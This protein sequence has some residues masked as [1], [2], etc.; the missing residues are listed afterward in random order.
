MNTIHAT[1]Q[2]PSEATH[3]VHLTLAAIR[4][5]IPRRTAASVI[6]F[7]PAHT[8]YPTCWMHFPNPDHAQ[9]WAR[10]Q[11]DACPTTPFVLLD[12]TGI[13]TST[14]T[15]NQDEALRLAMQAECHWRDATAPRHR[16]IRLVQQQINYDC[17]PGQPPGLVP[18]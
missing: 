4:R 18:A 17:P 1:L 15:P 12:A 10:L 6:M 7:C 9:E 8:W 2:W 3:Y 16:T 5:R 13:A 11:A 14:H